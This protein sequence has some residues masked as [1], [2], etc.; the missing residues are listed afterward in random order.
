MGGREEA[1]KITKS[2]LIIEN[3]SNRCEFD[4]D[5]FQLT[6]IIVAFEKKPEKCVVENTPETAKISSRRRN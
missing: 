5:I 1:E 3:K 4:F 6:K 2:S